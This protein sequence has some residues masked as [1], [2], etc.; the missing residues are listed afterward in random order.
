[1]KSNV[2]WSALLKAK[3]LSSPDFS[4][5]PQPPNTCVCITGPWNT[6]E[7]SKQKT[8]AFTEDSIQHTPKLSSFPQLLHTGCYPVSISKVF[9]HF[10]GSRVKALKQNAECYHELSALINLGCLEITLMTACFRR[11]SLLPDLP[12]SHPHVAHQCDL[13]MEGTTI[14]QTSRQGSLAIAWRLCQ[15]YSTL[16]DLTPQERTKIQKQQ[17]SCPY[18]DSSFFQFQAALISSEFTPHIFP[19]DSSFP[20]RQNRK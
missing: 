15:L 8:P 4:L 2:N 18:F 7:S 10:F 20:A 9:C 6:K 3:P 12:K 17:N 14:S 11:Q 16:T 1:M 5:T 19:S 13:T